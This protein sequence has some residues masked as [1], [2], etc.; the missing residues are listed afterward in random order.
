M[1]VLLINGSPALI[2]HTKTV[3]D[4]LANQCDAVGSNAEIIN[5]STFGLPINNPVHH[6]DASLSDNGEVR[7]FASKVASADCI[8]LGT[9]LYHGSFSG[10]LKSALD[11]LDGNAFEGKK[12]IL[13]SN[14][15]GINN[16]M[17]AGNELVVVCRTMYG[18]VYFRQ[19]GTSK[20]DFEKTESG[21]VIS[22]QDIIERC[23]AILD[24]VIL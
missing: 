14:S 24:A 19:I 18:D 11:N 17:Q 13:T 7:E 8:I 22:N 16:A 3:L 1:K 5:L 12:I 2:S 20:H 6:A 9:P 15:A 23:N 21:Y 4:Y 10:L